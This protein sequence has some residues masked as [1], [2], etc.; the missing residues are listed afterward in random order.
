MT[1]ACSFAPIAR[2]ATALGNPARRVSMA[3]LSTLLLG[4]VPIMSTTPAIAQDV[5]PDLSSAEQAALSESPMTQAERA[6]RAAGC[7]FQ[8]ISDAPAL[9]LPEGPEGRYVILPTLQMLR[10]IEMVVS[11]G[12]AQTL[13]L[14]AFKDLPHGGIAGR[15]TCGAVI[16]HTMT[17]SAAVGAVPTYQALWLRN[18]LDLLAEYPTTGAEIMRRSQMDTI[19]AAP[20]LALN[21]N[22][23]QTQGWWQATGGRTVLLQ[24]DAPA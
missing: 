11:D 19:P 22:D 8:G 18:D 20:Y 24:P 3:A 12:A 17:P 5:S 21:L 10:I 16:V 15:D 23:P 1:H 13:A 4:V 9:S 14:Q 7:R 2:L 6:T